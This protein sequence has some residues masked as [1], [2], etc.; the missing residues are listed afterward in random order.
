MARY[1]LVVDEARHDGWGWEM[2]W[3]L[4][5]EEDYGATVGDSVTTGLPKEEDVLPENLDWYYV[6]VAARTI[7][8]KAQ[9]GQYG[10]YIFESRSAAERAL[11]QVRARVKFLRDKRPWPTWAIE[12]QAQGWTAPK[13]WKP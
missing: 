2:V 4:A 7:C 12:A 5:D 8:A 9:R 13:G 6:E 1:R 10:G 3:W 11:R